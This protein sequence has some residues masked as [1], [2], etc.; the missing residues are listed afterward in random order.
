V[1]LSKPMTSALLSREYF[2]DLAKIALSQ[3]NPREHLLLE[4]FAESSQFIRINGARVR[5]TG[6][7]DDAELTL[8]LIV[9]SG[10]GELRKGSYAVTLQG[11][12]QD[13]DEVTRALRKLQA[14]VPQLPHDPFAE[15]PQAYSPSRVEKKGELLPLEGAVEE[16]L[17][18]VEKLDL[19]GIYAAGPCV[20]AMA[21][22]TGLI[23]WF[24]TESFQFDYSVYTPDQRTVKSLYAGQ[25][26]N[27]EAYLKS[28]DAA[29]SK[30]QYMSRPPR[31]VKRGSY[32]V[33]LEP[34]AMGELVQMMAYDTFSEASIRQG[35][36]PLQQ[37]RNGERSFSPLL[38]LT[39]DYRNEE[40]PRFNDL[41]ELA[42]E[43]LVL[44]EKG[45]LT[46]TLVSSRS[47]KEYGVTA[48][49][50]S[51]DET[52]R[53]TRISTGNL[54]ERDLLEKLGTG[55][56]LSNLHYLNWSDQP[57]GRITGMTR[58]ACFWV[59]NSKIQGP[60]EN[61]RFDD[62]LFNLL[63]AHLEAVTEEASYLA[64]T[65]SYGHRHLGGVATPGAL[66][67]GMEFTL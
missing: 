12:Y 45:K 47:H 53:A 58:Y 39:E 54:A 52:L 41:G 18:P 50:A 42:P 49:G 66:L 20:R 64:E 2:Q 38:T 14:E 35:D 28:V 44:I 65:L 62:S 30:L 34:A 26:W 29:Q 56:Y 46:Q 25:S 32:R 10:A 8:S 13:R 27:R 37:V 1:S 48:N 21:N 5:Q 6:T 67:S 11:T 16:I 51:A 31:A 33:Y 24:N 9:E 60:I 36:S 15:L 61:M 55:L 4:Y 63:G 43:R 7:V 17:K 3:L 57:R 19:V 23:H 40:V 59:E 22:S